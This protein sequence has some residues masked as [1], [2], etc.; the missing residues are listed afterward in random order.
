MNSSND[1]LGQP[2]F[3]VYRCLT[4]EAKALLAQ[5]Y[6]TPLIFCWHNSGNFARH[7]I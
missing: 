3:S 2:P 1:T 5:T 7:L 6:P 4:N